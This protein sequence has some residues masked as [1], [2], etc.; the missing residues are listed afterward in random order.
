MEGYKC[1]S[2]SEITP[3]GKADIS[4]AE[5]VCPKCGNDVELIRLHGEGNFSYTRSDVKY[6]N[7]LFPEIGEEDCI[8]E[9]CTHKSIKGSMFCA[10]HYFE[11]SHN[12]PCPWDI[13]QKVP[14]LFKIFSR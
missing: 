9:G 11:I 5:L 12:K 10:K 14:K 7:E 3:I 4:G 1:K 2:C 8:E 6:F 13:P